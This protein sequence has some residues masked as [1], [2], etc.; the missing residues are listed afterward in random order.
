MVKKTEY[1]TVQKMLH[2]DRN[3]QYRTVPKLQYGQENRIQNRIEAATQIE[4]P[5]TEQY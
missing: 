5:N 3:T 4:M 1:K 2:I